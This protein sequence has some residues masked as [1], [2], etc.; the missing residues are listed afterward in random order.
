MT[1]EETIDRMIE[2]ITAKRGP[3]EIVFQPASVLKLTGLVQLALR[4]PELP[5]ESR[6]MG[7]GFLAGVREYFADSPTVLG[8]IRRGDD[9]N[10]DR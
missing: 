6:A 7:E 1:D 5:R 9:P 8:V 3:M 10:E 4:H 2:E